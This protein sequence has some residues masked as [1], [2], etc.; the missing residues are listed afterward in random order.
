MVE[1]LKIQLVK[2]QK[3]I[4]KLQEE[5]MRYSGHSTGHYTT[6][7]LLHK[8]RERE[9]EIRDITRQFEEIEQSFIKKESIFK[10]SKS[11]M[12]QLLKEIGEAK[13]NNQTLQLK[14]SRIHLQAAQ[15]KSL[16]DQL[17]A[18]QAERDQLEGSIRRITAEPFF[19]REKGQ[20]TLK[21]IAELEEKLLEK[22]KVLAGLKQEEAKKS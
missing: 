14:N 4:L 18:L 5:K 12:E 10:D 19:N 21:R 13:I 3:E 8:I 17:H 20:S 6:D 9:S 11:Y 15:A 7:N 2:N 1:E 16:N 22:E